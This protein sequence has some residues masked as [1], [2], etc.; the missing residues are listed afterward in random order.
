[1]L[2]FGRAGARSSTA[3]FDR[4]V[5]TVRGAESK[6]RAGPVTPDGRPAMRS[7]SDADN[8]PDPP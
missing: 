2:A 3:I 7:Q 5:G 1:M 6:C 8:W 4:I